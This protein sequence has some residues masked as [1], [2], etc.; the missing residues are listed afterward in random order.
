MP[1]TLPFLTRSDTDDNLFSNVK[2][3][4]Q[5][6]VDYVNGNIVNADINASAA[7]AYSKL[8]L[9]NAIL[10]GDLTSNSVTTAK[11]ADSNVTTAKIA[12]ANVTPAKLSP[13]ATSVAASAS[14]TLTTSF[15]DVANCTYTTTAAGTFL[16]IGT[17]HFSATNVDAGDNPQLSGQLLVNAVAQ[18]P[19]ASFSIVSG[20]GAA[21]D[22]GGSGSVGQSW[23]KS[24]VSSG[25][26]IKLQAK[27]NANFATCL[28][29]AD[30][31]T[32]TVVQIG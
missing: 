13:T 27:R 18:T 31:T 32:L 28:A 23:I 16:I 8:A 6:I 3:N 26:V 1:I 21:N 25:H 9:T 15:Q 12:N 30:N 2:D 7:I 22:A 29:L 24:G 5:A 19:Q 11:I 14:L 4:D 10:A 20:A 17:F